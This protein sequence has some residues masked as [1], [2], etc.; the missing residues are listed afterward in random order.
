MKK[1]ILLI[2]NPTAGK[3]AS[4]MQLDRV[5]E[6][7]AR[8]GV[9]VTEKITK[10]QFDAQENLKHWITSD[11]HEIIC[12]G[13]DGT[14][15][16]IINGMYPHNLP[17]RIISSGTGNDLIKAI[18]IVPLDDFFTTENF[19]NVNMFRANDAI[20]INA[21]GIG[22]DGEV[23]R[24]MDENNLPIRGLMAYMIFVIKH[25]L[26]FVPPRYDIIVDGQRLNDKFYIALVANGKA[27]GGGFFL[28]PDADPGDDY[29]DL[30]LIRDLPM[31]MRPLFV[32]K[33]LLKKH[34]N[35]R[36]VVMR[37]IKHILIKS[38]RI[39]YAQLD[40]QL[41]KNDVFNIEL[42]KEKLRIV[43]GLIE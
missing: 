26:G 24:S 39:V 25:L 33:V 23:V 7:L 12:M 43:A 18:G 1:N 30:C 16:E 8:M 4:L 19:S 38:N 27:I 2:V 31:I 35:D 20:G 13:G 34:I 36:N 9:A 6:I 14:L 10:R 42:I 22:F 37:R 17:V 32:I 21:L 29:L 11:T 3:G 40:G 5:R 41:V 15:N 28:T